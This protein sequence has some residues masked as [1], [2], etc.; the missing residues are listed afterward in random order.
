MSKSGAKD[1][2]FA[3]RVTKRGVEECTALNSIYCTCNTP[4][5]F[6][7]K[8]KEKPNNVEDADI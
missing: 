8:K 2:C 1:D 3:Y 5:H 7:K 4:C 6:Y